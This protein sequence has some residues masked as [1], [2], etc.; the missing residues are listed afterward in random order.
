MALFGSRDACLVSRDDSR[1]DGPSHSLGLS[2]LN[3]RGDAILAG[4]LGI[5][6]L[7]W[8]GLSAVSRSTVPLT[9]P[10]YR[11]DINEATWTDWLHVEGV[12][13]TLATRI[14]EDRTVNGP[15]ASIDE[16]TRVR[17]IG[18]KTVDAM[19]PFLQ[20]DVDRPEDR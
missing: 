4:I 1:L 16:L 13:D 2:I 17:G 12:G 3:L 11:L 19:R 14:I 5:G 9:E 10:A 6:L 8:F 18:E 7:G 20:L 15:F